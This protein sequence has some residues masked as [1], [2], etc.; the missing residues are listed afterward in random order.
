MYF[1]SQKFYRLNVTCAWP[2]AI[3]VRDVVAGIFYFFKCFDVRIRK[4][5]PYE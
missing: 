5:L 4:V 2:L 3:A 1:C